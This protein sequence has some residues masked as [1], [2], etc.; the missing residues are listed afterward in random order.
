VGT[1][2]VTRKNRGALLNNLLD[3]KTSESAYLTTCS[4]KKGEEQAVRTQARQ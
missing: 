3:E 2:E 4:K 1:R